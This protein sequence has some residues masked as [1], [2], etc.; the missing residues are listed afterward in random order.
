M[1][2]IQ[3]Y[4]HTRISSTGKTVDNFILNQGP[5]SFY[6]EDLIVIVNLLHSLDG[7]ESL[8]KFADD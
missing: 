8:Q 3:S 6:K 2:I 5:V 7:W 1:K 4:D